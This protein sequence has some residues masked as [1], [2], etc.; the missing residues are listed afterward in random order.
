MDVEVEEG[1]EEGDRENEAGD[2]HAADDPGLDL[3]TEPVTGRLRD[4]GDSEHG[5]GQA[6]P[7]EQPDPHDDG[8]EQ[9]AELRRCEGHWRVDPLAEGHVVPVVVERS[10]QL[11]G[12]GA[13]Q[14]GQRYEGGRQDGD[15]CPDTPVPKN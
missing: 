11:L 6:D 2:P 1:A 8:G 7:D 5:V 13:D 3:L 10:A 4:L 9:A 15:V 14:H 12:I